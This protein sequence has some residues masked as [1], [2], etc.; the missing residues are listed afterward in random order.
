MNAALKG[1]LRNKRQQEGRRPD[2]PAYLP[3]EWA[4]DIAP[5]FAYRRKAPHSQRFFRHVPPAFEYNALEEYASAHQGTGQS[6]DN[7]NPI[8]SDFYAEGNKIRPWAHVRVPAYLA[9]PE[10][11]SVSDDTFMGYGGGKLAALGHVV[12]Q[13]VGGQGTIDV[14]PLIPEA[15]FTT[16]GA[17][18]TLV[19][20]EDIPEDGY[21]YA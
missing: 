17:M 13:M 7:S 8:D 11:E 12:P 19:P 16:Y 6:L 14:S 3:G 5:G 4:G 2:E 15:E 10:W 9:I 1:M 18:N 21:L 20:G